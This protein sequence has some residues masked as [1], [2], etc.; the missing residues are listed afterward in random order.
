MLPLLEKTIEKSTRG[1]KSSSKYAKRAKAGI[2]KL[3][4]LGY[5]IDFYKLISVAHNNSVG[6][7][8]YV[9]KFSD[10][11]ST[12]L[13]HFSDSFTNVRKLH[14]KSCLCSTKAML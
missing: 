5:L 2:C 14:G 7:D 3:L 8:E 9:A 4:Y 13:K 6:F 12:V 11:G 10:V 1:D